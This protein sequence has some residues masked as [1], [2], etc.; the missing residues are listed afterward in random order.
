MAD[1]APCGNCDRKG[2]G[3]YHDIC[4]EYLE[5]R[6]H[7]D[8]A[9]NKSYDYREYAYMRRYSMRKNSVNRKR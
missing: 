8:E 7:R 9:N 4:P 2:C 6:K 1:V 3:S 5:Y